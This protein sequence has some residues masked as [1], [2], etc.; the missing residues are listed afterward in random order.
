[1]RKLR[2]FSLIACIVY[3]VNACGQCGG[4]E[5]WAVKDGTDPKASQ[6]HLDQIHSIS[7]PQLLSITE[8]PLPHSGDNET[9]IIP[10]ETHL[11][12]VQA[13]LVKWKEESGETGDS[14]YHLVLTD[15]TLEYTGGRQKPSGH[16][17]V[18]EVPDPDCLAGAHGNFGTTSPFLPV[19]G[20]TSLSIRGARQALEAQFPEAAFDGTW[21]DAGGI[22][23]EVVGV[24]YFD[25]PHGQVGRAPNNIEIHPILS[26]SFSNHNELVGTGPPAAATT[27]SAAAPQSAEAATRIPPGSW[28]YTMIS[29]ESPESLLSSANNLGI[30]GW[31]LI[32][33][34][35]DA[36]NPGA[37]IGYLKR[38]AK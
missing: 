13:R 35:A 20:S 16:S 7:I 34:V 17:F 21:N 37:Y 23:V 6:V 30:D 25:F 32:S 36:K 9:R 26:I 15:D 4:T 5:R 12:R 22:P 18:G 10:Q 1:M 24:G 8:P 29:A 38:L 11:Y 14:D 33:V 19:S 31:E 28:Q 3:A 2:L 27:L